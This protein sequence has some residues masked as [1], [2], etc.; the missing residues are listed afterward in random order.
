MKYRAQTALLSPT[1]SSLM[2]SLLRHDLPPA[3]FPTVSQP[4]KSNF[5]PAHLR[6]HC[7]KTPPRDLNADDPPSRLPGSRDVAPFV[8]FLLPLPLNFAPTLI[9]RRYSQDSSVSLLSLRISLPLSSR[10]PCPPM[11]PSF[12]SFRSDCNPYTHP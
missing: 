6:Y 10:P 5:L 12:P 7:L 9:P 8:A 11:V 2:C 3:P 1:R 4:L